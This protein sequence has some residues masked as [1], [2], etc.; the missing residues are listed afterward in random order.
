MLLFNEDS[1]LLFICIKA[2]NLVVC[3]YRHICTKV[4]FSRE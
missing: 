1:D 4:K 2:Y 3:K